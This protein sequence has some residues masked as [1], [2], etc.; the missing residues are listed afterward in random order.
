MNTPAEQVRTG[1]Y[2]PGRFAKTLREL[3]TLIVDE[4]SMVRADLFDCL[5]AA[6]ERFGP[7]PGRKYGGVQL[8]LVGDLYQLPPVVTDYER[9]HFSTRY[10]TPYFSHIMG[11]Y[12][13]GYYAY[14][15]SEVLDHDAFQWFRENGGMTR[16]NGQVFRDKV[17][18]IGHTRDLATAYREFRGKDPS[19]EPLLEHRGL[20]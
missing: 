10:K 20:K 19:V 11:G 17:L 16:E 7:K 3:H 18:S 15:G 8:V 2:F 6:L 12:A 13:A 1:K 9:E 14:F 5:V 4:A